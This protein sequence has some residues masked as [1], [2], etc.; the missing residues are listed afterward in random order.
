MKFFS[1]Y[2]LGILLMAGSQAAIAAPSKQDAMFTTSLQKLS[3]DL[4]IPGIAFAVIRDGEI[5]SKGQLN[6]NPDSPPLTLDTPL[7][8]ASVTKALT[9]VALMRAVDRGVLSLDDSAAKWLPEF[10]DRPQI[11]VRH[12]AAHVS[13]GAPGVEYVYGTQRY[14]KLG[15]ILE[16]SSN[17][18]FEELLR[19][20]IVTPLRM[21]WRDSPALGAH[22]GFV[23]TVT[24]MALFVQ[25]LQ[26]DT[27][28]K[29]RRFDEM[30]TP[31]RSSTGDSP[32]GVGFFAQQIGGTRVVWSFGQDDP[33]H[34][35]ALLLMVPKRKLA[36][37]MLA[38]TDELSN[39]FRLLMGDIRYSPFATAFLDAYAPDVGKGIT[40]RERAAQSALVAVWN[41]DR[42][43]ATQQFRRFSKLGAARADD[44]VPHFLGTMLGD[45]ESREFVEGLD[46]TVLAAHPG[47]RWVLLMSAGLHEELGHKDAA[48]ERYQAL[49]VLPNQEQDGLA[50][51]F[52]AWTYGGL[53]R[54]SQASDPRIAREYVEKGLAT[55]VT[56]GTREELLALRKTLE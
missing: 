56:G 8:F 55:G 28:F 41:Q 34:S 10:A 35:S 38:N 18:G 30:T 43:Q 16:K 54:L 15:A 13:E 4:T 39:P 47:N 40:E 22:A 37:V 1:W 42:E 51:L 49:L 21:T 48:A 53:A 33:D 50:T 9:A 11:T 5:V 25:A 44:M 19:K 31:Y 32:A 24:D 46:R 7:R 3:G 2:V 17:T 20:E 36:L 12:L 14:A 29:P 52:R 26:R 6:A 23:S 27:F 45:P